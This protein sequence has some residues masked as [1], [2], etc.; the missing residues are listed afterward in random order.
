VTSVVTPMK[1][2]IRF[3]KVSLKPGDKRRLEF[4][5]PALEMAVWNVDMKRVVEPG[6]FELMVGPAAED[7]FIKLRGKFR[8]K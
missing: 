3:L 8:V 7:G 4:T 1:R 2:L 6:T 5:I